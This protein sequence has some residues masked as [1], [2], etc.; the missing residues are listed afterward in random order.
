MDLTAMPGAV[1][2]AAFVTL[3]GEDFDFSFKDLLRTVGRY[4]P[5]VFQYFPYQVVLEILCPKTTVNLWRTFFLM[6]LFMN[7]FETVNPLIV[8]LLMAQE[9]EI[10]R[11][12]TN[13]SSLVTG[14]NTREY[15][16]DQWLWCD[17]LWEGRT[18]SQRAQVLWLFCCLSE[19]EAGASAE[20]EAGEEAL[21]VWGETG[22]CA[23]AAWSW[24]EHVETEWLPGSIK[25]H[26][27]LA[28]EFNLRPVCRTMCCPSA[29]FKFMGTGTRVGQ[30]LHLT[31]NLLHLGWSS[32]L[33][34]RV[35]QFK[36]R[37]RRVMIMLAPK[38]GR[39]NSEDAIGV[40]DRK[41]VG[42]STKGWVKFGS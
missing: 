15:E 31:W 4:S 23:V 30:V 33:A 1:H 18:S 9:A 42:R 21:E 19:W 5:C 32:S 29:T 40:G 20:S 24:G 12:S 39:K 22:R 13:G 37:G 2:K 8:L 16:V 14:G 17:S 7:L 27:L 34:K 25:G 3:R 36:G 28:C 10:L 6:H 38:S 35:Q 41:S 11:R 26:R